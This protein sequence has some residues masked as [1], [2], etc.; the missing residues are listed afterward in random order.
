[1]DILQHP[2]PNFGPRRDGDA[3][4][5]II[6][7]YTDVPD[8][9]EALRLMCDP[10]HKASAHYLIDTDGSVTQL[11]DEKMRA[12]HAGLSFW[13]EERDINSRSIG[14]EIQNPGHS[15][16][17][18]AFPAKQ[19]AAV[20]TL[21]RNIMRRYGLAA[22]GV[23]GH[24]DIAPDRKIDPGEYFPWKKFAKDGMGLWPDIH[25]EDAAPV[26]D[27]T[28]RSWLTDIG[29]DPSVGFEAVLGAF[30]RH[31]VPE[32]FTQGGLLGRGDPLTV[33][34]LRLL[35]KMTQR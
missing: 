21:C 17:Y 34:R 32:L 29:Y 11:V 18:E 12:W 23:L 5:F 27:K 33:A 4:R 7:H 26:D 6:L 28:L 3:I 35:H 8:A 15:C 10:A 1:M 13:R 14:I 24:S 31:Y 22:D 30:Q 9:A 19:I 2:S 20:E 25:A 16:G